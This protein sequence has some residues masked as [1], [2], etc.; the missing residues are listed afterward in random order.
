MQGDKM[1]CWLLGNKIPGDM[2]LMQIGHVSE[3]RVRLRDQEWEGGLYPSSSLSTGPG[4]D[5][6]EEGEWGS[7]IIQL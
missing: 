5:N 4:S 6:Y 1:I 7:I 2:F 3:C